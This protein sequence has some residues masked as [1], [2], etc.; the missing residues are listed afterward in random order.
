[1]TD[2]DVA[3]RRTEA[4][5]ESG[6]FAD[7]RPTYRAIMRRLKQQD[8]DA[9]DEATR[10]YEEVLAPAL[11]DEDRDPLAAWAEFGSWLA[12]RLG[13]GRLV[14]LDETGLAAAAEPEPVSG[15]VLL[16][17]P[18]SNRDSA[19]PLLRPSS[20]SEPQATALDLLVR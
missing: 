8:A 15:H 17:L 5:L 1:M 6:G 19:I 12:R 7:M 2:P 3:G 16:F 4:A 9:F 18:D 13:P 11:A 14:R 10:R 20:P